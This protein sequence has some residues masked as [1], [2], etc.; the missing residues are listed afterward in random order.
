MK[1]SRK[2][3]RV[4]CVLFSC[5]VL[6]SLFPAAVYY[7]AGGRSPDWLILGILGAGG[8]LIAG[9]ALRIRHLRCP[10]CGGGFA[11]P[12]WKAGAREYCP[13]CGRPFVYDD[14]ACDDDAWPGDEI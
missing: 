11:R 10:H 3:S 9:V 1:L 8:C 7:L 2:W 13:A 12:L 6:L 5:A 14:E 4:I